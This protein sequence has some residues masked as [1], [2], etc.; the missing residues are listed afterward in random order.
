MR[1]CT[2]V[3]GGM[4][5]LLKPGESMRRNLFKCTGLFEKMRG[6]GHDYKALRAGKQSVGCSI[7]LDDG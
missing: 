1:T 5:V 6:A 4:K 3:L 2:F 7:H